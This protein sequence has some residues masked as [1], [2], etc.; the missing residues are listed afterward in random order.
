MEPVAAAAAAN[1]HTPQPIVE[2]LTFEDERVNRYVWYA[3]EDLP[4]PEIHGGWIKRC[5]VTPIL[6]FLIWERIND[7]PEDMRKA[8]RKD[9]M[10]RTHQEAQYEIRPAGIFNS[11]I[12]QYGAL[13]VRELTAL[14]GKTPQE[15]AALNLDN[16]FAPWHSDG[17]PKPYRQI[18][19][20]IRL[21]LS[22]GH[23]T[24]I[25]RAVGEEMLGSIVTA[26]AY[27]EMFVDEEE[28]RTDAE[29]RPV[30]KYSRPGLRALS[31]LGRRRRDHAL[32]DM[33]EADLAM[34]K[35]AAQ[36]SS[37]NA[38]LVAEMAEQN[39][40]KREELELRREELELNRR[41]V[42]KGKPGRKPKQAEVDA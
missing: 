1:W 21:T 20:H 11:I 35:A 3:G 25:Q 31:R 22:G 4:W 33:A 8:V 2:T 14:N 13:G 32:T 23:L 5:R 18:E 26:K 29:G 7:V 24:P 41:S 42:A 30:L 10:D 36:T 16:M 12:E 6:P 28:S 40:L 38:A 17:I 9:W 34:K 27:D 39:R 15:V 37:D 19:E